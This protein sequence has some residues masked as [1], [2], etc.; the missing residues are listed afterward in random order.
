MAPGPGPS[1]VGDRFGEEG[2]ALYRRSED[3]TC[4]LASPLDLPEGAA[5]AWWGEEPELVGASWTRVEWITRPA[6]QGEELV[7]SIVVRDLVVEESGLV[8][9]PV[10]P[11]LLARTA[12]GRWWLDVDEGLL[13][14]Q[15]GAEDSQWTTARGASHRQT[16]AS[17]L[18]TSLQDL[19]EMAQAGP[20]EEP[21]PEASPEE[22]LQAIMGPSPR[23]K[24]HAMDALV[25]HKQEI[26]PLL[27]RHLDSIYQSLVEGRFDTQDFSCL[28]TLVL[29]A[30][31]RY[32][33]AHQCLL[34]PARL[35]RDDFES[36]MGGFLTEGYDIALV[37]T[38]GSDASGIRS[39]LLDR[40]VNEYLRA[41]A[42]DALVGAVLLGHTRR[43]EALAFLASLLTPEHLEEGPA[44]AVS[45]LHCMGGLQRQ[46]VHAWMEWWACFR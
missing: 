24:R 36:A 29:L 41:Q 45:S 46:D 3:G 38:C 30:H 37:A 12:D 26:A 7:G 22:L 11:V 34:A 6:W 42:A 16:L 21:R 20:P 32:A 1:V 19:R 4:T 35:P 33:P 40:S 39:L 31:F 15:L 17:F 14:I 44:S 27:L 13:S 23:Q 28:Y 9:S 10:V 5:V 8:W 2:I 18:Q 43:D 25:A